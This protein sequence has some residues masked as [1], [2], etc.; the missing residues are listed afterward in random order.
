MCPVRLGEREAADTVL[1]VVD[2]T[3]SS[4]AL[5]DDSVELSNA[6]RLAA[7]TT[8]GHACPEWEQVSA[9]SVDERPSQPWHELQA[10]AA[11]GNVWAERPDLMQPKMQAYS[12]PSVALPI[13]SSE[14]EGAMLATAL[15]RVLAPNSSHWR[16][17]CGQTCSAAGWQQ[18]RPWFCV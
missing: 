14:S 13:V 18:S 6:R 17:W 2:K 16:E 1:A 9:D 8:S 3:M 4:Y 10:L 15:E 12:E 11:L 7:Q 5:R